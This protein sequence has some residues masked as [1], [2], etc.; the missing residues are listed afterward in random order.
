MRVEF[1]PE[2]QLELAQAALHYEEQLP[3]LG[4]DLNA[5][6]ERTVSLLVV[7]PRMGSLL[8]AEH[9]RFS[10]Q[11]FPFSLIYRDLGSVLLV[12]AVAHKRRRPRYWADRR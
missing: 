1:H 12:V 2:A 11:R 9:R 10:V 3:G 6:V 5:E 7:A 4:L 8:D